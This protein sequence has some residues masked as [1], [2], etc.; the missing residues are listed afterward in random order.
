DVAKKLLADC[1]QDFD[2]LKK[3]AITKEFRPVALNAKA[4]IDIKQTL[5]SFKSHNVIGKF[6]GAD[7]TVKDEYIIYT[8]H[9]DHLGRHPEL[10]GDQIIKGVVDKASGDAAVIALAS[11]FPKADPATRR[12]NHFKCTTAKEAGLLGAKF[13]AEHPLYSLEKTLADINM[14]SLNVWGKARDVEDTSFGLSTLD[15]M[16]ADAAK[17]QGRAAISNSRPEKG[18]FYRAD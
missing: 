12:S 13:Y 5:R 9:W 2:S 1:G 7:P 6:E 16:L 15:D 14:D 4:N 11:A 3:S 8:A 17:R 18:S 10:Q